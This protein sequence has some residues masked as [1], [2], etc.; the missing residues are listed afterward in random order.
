M[1]H[2]PK[3]HLKRLTQL[4]LVSQTPRKEEYTT[5]LAVLTDLKGTN[6]AEVLHKGANMDSV[7][8]MATFN[9]SLKAQK[10]SSTLC[11]SVKCQG[12]NNK[13]GNI[14][15]EGNNSSLKRW[16]W[17]K[18]WGSLPHSFCFYCS[19]CFQAQCLAVLQLMEACT[20]IQFIEHI[21]SQ[22]SCLHTDLDITTTCLIQQWE[23]S[24]MNRNW[25][26]NLMRKLRKI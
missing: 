14:K 17:D 19:L 3:K 26:K 9:K 7:S 18:S 2:R 15:V 12:S 22:M 5:K 23:I 10:I 24:D 21:S 11:F 6:L 13:Q 16:N 20:I 4:W 8:A 25:R 1:L